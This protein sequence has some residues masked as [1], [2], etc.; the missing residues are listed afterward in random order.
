MDEKTVVPGITRRELLEAAGKVAAFTV[1]AT[2][3]MGALG[4]VFTVSAQAQPQPL[5][6]IAGIDR[7]VMKTG[8]TYLNGWAGYGAP[9]RPG[10]QGGG[11]GRGAAA[12]PTPPPAPPGPAP[13]THGARCRD[14]APSHSLIR[15]PP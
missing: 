12:A 8:K 7:V 5:T 6:A 2:P 1:V 13:T 3:V 14:R 4:G 11:G 9:P 10:R 15:T